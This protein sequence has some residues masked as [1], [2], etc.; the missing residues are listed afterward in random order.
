MTMLHKMAI[1]GDTL[2][3]YKIRFTPIKQQKEVEIDV[4]DDGCVN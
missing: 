1:S 2:K 3:C 4:E